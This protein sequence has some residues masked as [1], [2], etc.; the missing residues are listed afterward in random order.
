MNI[1]GGCL[2]PPKFNV[3]WKEE[4]QKKRKLN[5]RFFDPHATGIHWPEGGNG[6]YVKQLSNGGDQNSPAA[7]QHIRG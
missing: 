2:K 1:C 4:Y 6:E 7:S 3:E 5:M